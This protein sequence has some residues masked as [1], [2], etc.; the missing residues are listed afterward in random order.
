MRIESGPRRRAVSAAAVV[1]LALAASARSQA[2][3]QGDVA[4]AAP[5]STAT[6][7]DDRATSPPQEVRDNLVIQTWLD[8]SRSL[9]SRIASTRRQALEVGAWDLDPAARALIRGTSVGTALER[10]RG[11]VELAPDLPAAHLALARALWIDENAPMDAFRAVVEGLIAIGRHPEASL[12]FAGN[13]LVMLSAALLGGGLLVILLAALAS[14]PHAVHDLGHVLRTPVPGFAGL[15]LLA[16]LLMVPLVL[17][18]GLLGLAVALA[19]M[20][21]FYGGRR[22][23]LALALATLALFC[24]LFPLPRLAADALTEFPTDPVARA[25]YSVA[26]G[27]GSPVD[28]ARL[29]SALGKDP[30]A[31]R[32]LAI[33]A[34][35]TGNLG[36]AD[37]LYQGLLEK[38]PGDVA[39]LN[40]AANVRLELGHLHSALDLYDK[41]NAVHDSPVVL[42][43]L[44]QAFGRSFMVDDLNRTLAEAQRADGE[45]VAEFTTL[46]RTK[47]KSF[48][49]DFPLKGRV[50]WQRAL[51]NG[52]GEALASGLRAWIAPGRLGDSRDHA[53]ALLALAIGAAWLLALRFPTSCGC[54]RCGRRRC[55]R[56]GHGGGHGELCE[57][58]TRLFYQPEKTDRALRAD[59]L[60]ALALREQRMRRLATLGSLLIPGAA[61]LLVG[62]PLRSLVAS[63]CFVLAASAAFW[64]QGLVA[65]PLVA[66]AAAPVAFLGIAAVSGLVY[67]ALV[68]AC[69]ASRRGA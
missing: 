39:L 62:K 58:C 32:G 66:G 67:V 18:E 61:G 41:A 30:L 13:G 23:R 51:H 53:A 42:F 44:S 27:F 3:P 52:S 64:H 14:G 57:S 17:G 46:Q 22:Q 7:P 47:D 16:A 1:L 60:Q 59:R 63:V 36:R 9:E 4:A 25:A 68:S 8:R 35:Q 55:A 37:A 65:D 12:W 49:V 15:A 21:M 54:S 10:A 48:V 5:G 6:A 29:E 56:C 19:S 2:L 38:D 40:N 28:L 24:G 50:V 33:H 31:A 69:I 45:L 11:A 26:Q 43:N 34:R 20:G